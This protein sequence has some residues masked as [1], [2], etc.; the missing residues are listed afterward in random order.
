MGCHTSKKGSRK[1]REANA[2]RERKEI[3]CALC[4]YFLSA[5]CVKCIYK[6][7]SMGCYTSK[8]GSRKER[9]VNTRRERK[10]ILCALACI[11]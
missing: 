7:H 3:L 11:S 5:I 6:K 10:E 2:R 8:K 1:E 4:V 9:K